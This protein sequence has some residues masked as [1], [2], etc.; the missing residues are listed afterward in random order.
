MPSTEETRSYKSI[1]KTAA[2]FGG[3]LVYQI[4]IIIVRCKFVTVLLGTAGMGLQGLYQTSLS[5]TQSV[6]S[7]RF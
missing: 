2:L 6:T 4:L 1:F 3:V 7:R 5:L